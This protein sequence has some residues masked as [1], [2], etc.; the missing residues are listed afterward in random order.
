MTVAIR[1]RSQSDYK[2]PIKKTFLSNTF[3]YNWLFTVGFG[4]VPMQMHCP[5]LP[6]GG[7]D[8]SLSAN[9]IGGSQVGVVL[10]CEQPCT[11]TFINGFSK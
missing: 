9:P 2:Q 8:D 10:Q 11:R 5:G 7:T 3:F 1:P 6:S 4:L